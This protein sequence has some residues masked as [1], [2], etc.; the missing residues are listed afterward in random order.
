MTQVQGDQSKIN[1][2]TMKRNLGRWD[3]K[4]ERPR[5]LN[6]YT[7][8]GFEKLV[9]NISPTRLTDE[10]YRGILNFMKATKAGTSRNQI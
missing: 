7:W 1:L 10:T 5:D 6:E 9:E 3:H 8:L 4:R 2:N